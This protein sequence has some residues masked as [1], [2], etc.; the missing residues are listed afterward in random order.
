M[1]PFIRHSPFQS[2]FIYL[3]KLYWILFRIVMPCLFVK[4][5]L[6]RTSKRA[7]LGGFDTCTTPIIERRQLEVLYHTVALL[8]SFDLMPIHDLQT[9]TGKTYHAQD[10]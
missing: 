2:Q 5:S 6:N 4:R 7:S 9:S 1:I 8:T 3:L 10:H